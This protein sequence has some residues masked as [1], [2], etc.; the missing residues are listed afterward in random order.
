MTKFN[1]TSHNCFITKA[2]EPFC[3]GVGISLILSGFL[4]TLNGRDEYEK[5][6]YSLSRSYLELLQYESKESGFSYFIKTDD[7]NPEAT[8]FALLQFHLYRPVYTNIY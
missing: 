3:Q 2:A 7:P 5:L 1:S 8:A 6:K 4:G